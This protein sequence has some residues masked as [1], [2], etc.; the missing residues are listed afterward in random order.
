MVAGV[1]PVYVVV[2]IL[3]LFASTKAKSRNA[4]RARVPYISYYDF[5]GPFP[6]GKTEIDGDPVGGFESISRM[7]STRADH[8]SMISEMVD[9]GQ[10]RW[11][12]FYPDRQ[13]GRVSVHFGSD[14]NVSSIFSA[15]ACP[16]D[17]LQ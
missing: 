2:C 3:V 13:S 16:A 6:V 4:K 17:R 5:L 7:N 11:K 15:N 12:R 8:A 14:D 10:V 9:G 1:V